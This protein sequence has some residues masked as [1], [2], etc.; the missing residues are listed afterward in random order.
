[1]DLNNKVVIVTGGSSG[2]GAAT[3][4]LFTK[5]GSRVVIV[6]R[7]EKKLKNVAGE[8]EKLGNKPLVIVADVSKDPEAKRIIDTTVN[9]YGQIDVLVNNAGI[10]RSAGI[11]D[12]NALNLFDEIMAVNLRSVVYLTHLA[13]PYLVASKGNIINVSSIASTGVIAPKSFAYCTSKAGLDHFSRCVALEL[14]PKGVRCNIVNPGP[15]RTDII[16]NSGFNA[17]IAAAIWKSM[18][19]ATLLG[20]V[21]DSNEVAELVVF[22]ASDKAKGITGSSFVTDNGSSLLGVISSPIFE[23]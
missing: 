20:R 5:E 7:N 19:K 21:S 11:G 13:T 16:E 9:Q 17:E 1:M 12:E 6:G 3:A 10:S 22:L 18:E 4:L 15:V 14:A 8:C 2:I 23:Q